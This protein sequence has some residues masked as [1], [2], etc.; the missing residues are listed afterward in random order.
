MQGKLKN[1][2]TI[3]GFSNRSPS[4]FRHQYEEL[5][6][7]RKHM[8]RSCISRLLIAVVVI[9]LVTSASAQTLPP[10]TSNPC[11]STAAPTLSS[12]SVERVVDPAQVLSTIT[13]SIP[14][15]VSIGVQNKVLEIHETMTFDSQSQVLTL[16]LFPMQVGSPI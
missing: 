12:C 15:S 7:E 8:Y 10:T 14:A 13:P 5:I 9:C 6:A 3:S 16:N 4:N 1:R 11:P 2:C